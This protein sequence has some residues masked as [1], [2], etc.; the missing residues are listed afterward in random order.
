LD[1][2]DARALARLA[3]VRAVA[4]HRN[5]NAPEHDNARGAAVRHRP[6]S[7]L[8]SWRQQVR[9][10]SGGP[11]QPPASTVLNY[12]STDLLVAANRSLPIT[13]TPACAWPAAASSPG[14]STPQP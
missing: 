9:N 1:P 7:L 13:T 2:H 4:L 5:V 12:G 11:L 14:R 10:G 3:L 8:G 6:A